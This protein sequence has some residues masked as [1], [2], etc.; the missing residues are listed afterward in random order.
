MLTGLIL[1]GGP[2]SRLEG[3]LAAMLPYGGEP[4]ILHQIKEMRTICEEVIV[5]TPD[6]KPFLKVLDPGVRIITDYY[7]GKGPMGG[8]YAGFSLARYRHIWAVGSDMPFLSPRAAELLLERKREGFE[9]ALPL[10]GGGIYPLHG[11]YDKSCA[12]HVQSLLE[13]G[14]RSASSLLRSLYWA[15]MTDTVFLENGVDP[16][17]VR[18]F[19]TMDSYRDVLSKNGYGV[20][21]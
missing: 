19:D 17:F 6:P 21:G 3:R 16:D 20:A 1:A 18:S 14:E 13:E 10:I 4:L 8:M 11:V 2:E 12:H 7:V 5:A 9:A 15:D